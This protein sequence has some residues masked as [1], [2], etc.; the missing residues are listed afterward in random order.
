ME[1]KEVRFIVG[2]RVRENR[3][4]EIKEREKESERYEGERESQISQ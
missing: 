4:E 2:K 1:W 3:E